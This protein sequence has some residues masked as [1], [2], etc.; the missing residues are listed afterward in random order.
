MNQ[1]RF[2]DILSKLDTFIR[3]YYVNRL[4]KGGLYFIGIGVAFVL[5]ID[6]A[7]HVFR[8]STTGRQVLFFSSLFFL[9]GIFIYFIAIPLLKL[10]K[11][12]KQIDYKQASAIIGLHFSSVQDKLLNTLQLHEMAESKDASD[13]LLSSIEQKSMELQSVPFQRAID[14]K[15]NKR[16]L[17]YVL[18]PLGITFLILLISPTLIT[19]SSKRIVKFEEDFI[20]PAPFSFIVENTSLSVPRNLDLEV[21]VRIEGQVIP[22]VVYIESDGKRI[23]MIRKGPDQFSYRFKNLKESFRFQLQGDQYYSSSY[24]VDVLPNPGIKSFSVDLDY[25]AYLK[26]DNTSLTNQGDLIVPEGTKISWSFYTEDAEEL[27]MKI[28]D[29]L[30]LFQNEDERFF[31]ELEAEKSQY[32]QLYIRNEYKIGDDSLQYKLE[33]IPD[34]FPLIALESE[35]DSSSNQLWYFNGRVEDDY[36]FSQLRFYYRVLDNEDQNWTSTSIKLPP[37]VNQS[38]FFYV[39]E[40]DELNLKPGTNLEYYFQITDNDALHGGK[41]S[42]TKAQ[43]IKLPDQDELKEQEEE[44]NASLKDDLEDSAKEAKRLRKELDRLKKEFMQKKELDWQDKKQLEKL[45]DQQM[46]LQNKMSQINKDNI[47][48]QKKQQE[49]NKNSEEILEKQEQINKMFEELINDDM[50]KLYEEIQKLMEELQKEDLEK[51]MND[52]EFS[53]EDLEKELDRTLELFKQLELEKKVNDTTEKL[54]EL[55]KEEKDLAQES[56]NKENNKED[57]QKKQD[58]IKEEFDKL[59]KDMEDIQKK[60]EELENPIPLD[61]QKETQEE[62]DNEMKES[63]ENLDKNKRKNASESQQNAGEKMEQMANQMQSQMQAAEQESLEEDMNALRK[64]LSNIIDLSIDQEALMTSVVSTG[65]E[66]PKFKA[67]AQTQRKLKDDA[68]HIGDSLY[69]LSKRVPAIEPFVNKEMSLVNKNMG[70]ALTW[71]ADRNSANASVNQ[72]YAMTSL[73]NLSLFLDEALQKMQQQMASNMPG[74]GNCE[75]PGGQ[76]SK[77][78]ASDINKMQKS[79]AKQLEKL[80]EEMAKGENKGGSDGKKN[81]GM[82]KEI[83][84]M[85]AEQA[86]IRE[87]L[88]QLGQQLNENGKGEGNDYKKIAEAMEENEKDLANQDFSKITLMRQQDILSRLLK[89][90]KA[91]RE[92]E[93]DE[94]RKSQEAKNQKFSNPEQ[95]S[96]YNEMKRKESE[97]L[98]TLP[99]DLKPYYK[100]KVS[101]YFNKLEND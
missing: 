9:L 89:A 50:K 28:N 6:L 43:S 1:D 51:M 73:N 60:N 36:G 55:A 35:K 52:M 30:L 46:N 32:Y 5:I 72:Q 31:T 91:E 16:Y 54:K 76:G 68:R 59:K 84:Q 93:W 24:Q 83:A 79:L 62:I 53:N 61:D 15:K 10:L 95:F 4:I 13:L 78:S 86:A 101:E 58:E 92:R 100:K 66:D 77:P 69:A 2:T 33:V 26:M 44:A 29:S 98:E 94:E 82:S 56:L 18:I 19:S 57:L 41:S 96:K 80:K 97:M 25:P 64:L 34:R 8:F 37:G 48:N 65:V 38:L 49:F 74:S 99:P 90:E 71:M 45:M 81:Q 11:L 87:K 42:R 85:A 70:D 67:L 39:W 63:K 20:P 40:L 22:S 17:K 12:G 21:N 7:E 14:F 27:S 75:K 47:E 23:S 3:R 88:E